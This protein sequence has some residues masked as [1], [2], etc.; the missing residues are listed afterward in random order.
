MSSHCASCHHPVKPGRADHSGHVGKG[1]GF[2]SHKL[3]SPQ[4]LLK[5]RGSDECRTQNSTCPAKM[6]PQV[7]RLLS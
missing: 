7:T 2:G 6:D 3:A 4:K 5:V 1:G